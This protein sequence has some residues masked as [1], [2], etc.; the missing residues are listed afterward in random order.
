VG[1]VITRKAKGE[2]V[3]VGLG[4]QDCDRVEERLQGRRGG[5]RACMAQ[6][7]RAAGG[8]SPAG[9]DVV[10]HQDRQPRERGQRLAGRNLA[11]DARRGR[12]RVGLVDV[13]QRGEVGMPMRVGEQRADVVLRAE[14]AGADRGDHFG[15]RQAEL[16]RGIHVVVAP[17]QAGFF[18]RGTRPI[19]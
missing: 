9:I 16:G 2:L 19:R 1:T 11:V 12:E 8:R 13:D 17:P 18:S 7:R 5:R 15:R 4:A 10:L 14:R 3:Q 6:R